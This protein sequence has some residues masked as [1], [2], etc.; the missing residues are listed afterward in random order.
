M[1]KTQENL[2]NFNLFFCV[3]FAKRQMY[4]RKGKK[5]VLGVFIAG[6]A[7]GMLGSLGIGKRLA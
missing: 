6:G 4:M 5:I 7:I 3:I 2:I 1:R